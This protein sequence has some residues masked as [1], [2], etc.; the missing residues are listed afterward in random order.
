M[1]RN[2]TEA[3]DRSFY[4]MD[5]ACHNIA[6]DSSWGSA[7]CSLAPPVRDE[8]KLSKRRFKMPTVLSTS[9][10]AVAALVPASILAAA[11]SGSIYAAEGWSVV[12]ATMASVIAVYNA[13]KTDSTVLYMASVLVSTVFLGTVGPS[14]IFYWRN[15]GA[16]A[17]YPPSIYMCAGFFVGL[18]GWALVLAFMSAIPNLIQ[19]W[20]RKIV[21][22]DPPEKEKDEK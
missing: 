22:E 10:I 16:D 13:R 4:K 18:A 19:R 14:A 12:G 20:I 9:S 7:K 15:S 21:N 1:W 2:L 11:G 6:W 17:S 8:P 5:T 3:D